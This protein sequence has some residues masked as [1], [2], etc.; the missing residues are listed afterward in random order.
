[1]LRGAGLWAV[2]FIGS[3]VIDKT[4]SAGKFT[5]TAMLTL[6]KSGKS[7]D[8]SKNGDF[9]GLSGRGGASTIRDKVVSEFS[10]DSGV[11]IAALAEEILKSK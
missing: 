5:S 11:S 6:L 1:M 7:W 2:C 3:T 8:W 9:T 4:L 10:D